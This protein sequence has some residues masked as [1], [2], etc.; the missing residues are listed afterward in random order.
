MI[1]VKASNVGV[2]NRR[3]GLNTTVD[4]ER[5]FRTLKGL[6]DWLKH[7]FAS[8]T[9]AIKGLPESRGPSVSGLL[10][11]INCNVCETSATR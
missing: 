11:D 5:T 10:D 9:G 8:L 6:S 3:K 7:C 2:L 1:L 4:S